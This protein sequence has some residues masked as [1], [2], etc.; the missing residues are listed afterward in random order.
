VVVT[1][2]N[3]ALFRLQGGIYHEKQIGSLC[4]VHAMNNLMQGPAFNEIMLA[5]VALQVT[6]RAGVC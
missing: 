3:D 4:A 5:E 2:R 1:D 6:R